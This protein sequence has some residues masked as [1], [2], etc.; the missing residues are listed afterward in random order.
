MRENLLNNKT[1]TLMAYI[2]VKYSRP[3]QLVLFLII[4]PCINHH[5]DPFNCIYIK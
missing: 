5:K 1:N 4:I 2:I 3:L